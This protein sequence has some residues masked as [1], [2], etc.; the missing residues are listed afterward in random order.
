[1]GTN[2][3]ESLVEIQVGVIPDLVGKVVRQDDLGP[4]SAHNLEGTRVLLGRGS[5]KGLSLA[6]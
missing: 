4:S 5:E 3:G 6:A 1:M 2:L